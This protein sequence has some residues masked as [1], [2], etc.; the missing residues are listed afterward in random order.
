MATIELP[1]LQGRD[2]LGFL[3][4]LGVLALLTRTGNAPRLSF[5][6]TAPHYAQITAPALESADDIADVLRGVVDSMGEDQVIPGLSNWPISPIAA[7]TTSDPSRVLRSELPAVLASVRAESGEAG[8]EWL[9]AVLNQF[10]S[11]AKGRAALT[12]FMA[13]TGRQSIHTFFA[14]PLSLVRENPACLREA[15]VSWKRVEGCTGE[16]FDAAALRGA[17]ESS[18]GKPGSFGVPGATWLATMGLRLTRQGS[19]IGWGGESRPYTTLWRY[20]GGQLM[21]WP[22]WTPR[23]NAEGVRTMLELPLYLR[24]DGTRDEPLM[25][26]ETIKLTEGAGSETEI[27]YDPSLIHASGRVSLRDYGIHA[28]GGARRSGA[29]KSAG[30]LTAVPVTFGSGSARSRDAAPSVAPPS[31]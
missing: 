31:T 1:A 30:P 22:L 8:V 12:P 7:G 24:G 29:A 9:L 27:Q 5:A 15:L 25:V 28:V 11:D 19:H 3:A 10:H 21:L 26:S 17:A 14:K 18:D 6:Q 16:N 20:R 13:P 23:L 4:S 2:P